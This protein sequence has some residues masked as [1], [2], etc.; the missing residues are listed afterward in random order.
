[1]T[2]DWDLAAKRPV[3]VGHTTDHDH[4]ERTNERALS[5]ALRS[6]ASPL[7]GEVDRRFV[8]VRQGDGHFVRT[9]VRPWEHERS[10]SVV[11]SD[12]G[13][14]CFDGSLRTVTV[15]LNPSDNARHV[16]PVSV[17][18]VHR[19]P[20]SFGRCHSFLVSDRS[21]VCQS[22][23]GI[24][25]PGSP[26][27]PN[28]IQFAIRSLRVDVRAT[29]EKVLP[30]FVRLLRRQDPGRILGLGR[31][32][33]L[34]PQVRT[35]QLAAD[36]KLCCQSLGSNGFLIRCHGLSIANGRTNA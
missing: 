9:A 29:G 35:N 20:W 27:T 32:S 12:Q 17:P 31:A 10:V 30:H 3:A 4:R 23:A 15:E 25:L 21:F 5:S 36:P 19:S 22:V 11:R 28:L 34:R 6:L 16:E 7:G 8:L 24:L 26:R 18:F 14:R 2:T 1:M 13:E 33:V